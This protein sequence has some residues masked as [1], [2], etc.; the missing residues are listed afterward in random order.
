MYWR[1]RLA[2]LIELTDIRFSYPGHSPVLNGAAL[3]VSA[4]GRVC[5][6]GYNGAGKSTMLKLIVGL[7]RPD[8]GRTLAFGKERVREEDFHEVRCQAGFVFQDPDDQL[9]CPTVAEDIAFG[10]LNL[11]KSKDEARAIVNRVLDQLDLAYLRD[12]ITY[13]LLGGEKR[14]VSLTSVL[15]M[16]PQVLLLDE[17][18]NA[19]DERNEARLREILKDLPQAMVIV[20]H[21]ADFRENLG[22]RALHMTGGV[23]QPIA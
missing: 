12:R 7:L 11:G 10:P 8:S 2:R 14:L 21:D 16:D 4:G 15:A 9:F 18:T 19:L 17:P 20:S 1:S 5:I 23:L 13:K 3:T 6:S 22:T